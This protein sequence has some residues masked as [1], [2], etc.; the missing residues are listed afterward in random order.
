MIKLGFKFLYSFCLRL[1]EKIM[2]FARQS[3]KVT[4]SIIICNAIKMMDYP[5]QRQWFSVRFFPNK[6]M[7][8]NSSISVSSRMIWG[9][10]KN[11]SPA[12]YLYTTFPIRMIYP[13][14]PSKVYYKTFLTSHR[15]FVP[16]FF[17]TIRTKMWLTFRMLSFLRK[18]ILITRYS[19]RGMSPYSIRFS[20]LFNMACFIT[21]RTTQFIL[22]WPFKRLFTFYTNRYHTLIICYSGGICQVYK[23]V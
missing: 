21:R 2:L 3:Y 22:I 5:I 10:N 16:K 1:K 6:K 11:I 19:F 23:G 9:T 17:T 15:C 14:S 8:T 20:M 4:R 18:L 12:I 13:C 7:L